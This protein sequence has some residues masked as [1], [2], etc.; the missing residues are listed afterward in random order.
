[1]WREYC[2][3]T[4]QIHFLCPL[5]CDTFCVYCG[6]W[7]ALSL[8]SFPYNTSSWNTVQCINQKYIYFQ[9]VILSLFLSFSLTHAH[10]HTYIHTFMHAASIVKL[11]QSPSFNFVHKS[12]TFIKN[13]KTKNKYRYNNNN[14][15][16][17]PLGYFV[18]VYLHII[19][20]ERVESHCKPLD[21]ISSLFK[22]KGR[23]RPAYSHWSVKLSIENRNIYLSSTRLCHCFA[24]YCV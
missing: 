6:S 14:L 1:M 2:K 20:I 24:E 7:H 3:V 8:H 16:P 10:T 9:F 18:T 12:K 17:T 13:N 15:F 21:L 5:M 11:D 23:E 19:Y 22:S 4:S